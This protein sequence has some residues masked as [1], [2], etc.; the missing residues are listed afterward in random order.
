M[1]RTNQQKLCWKVVVSIEDTI[2]HKGEYISLSDVA[3]DL[4]L[5]YH[6]VA[7][8]STG[9]KRFNTNFKYQPKVEIKKISEVV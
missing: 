7:D 1:G 5:S 3:E 8:I 4:N 9:R 2:L 6:Q